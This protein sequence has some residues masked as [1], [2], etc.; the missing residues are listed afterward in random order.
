M[1]RRRGRRR[2]GGTSLVEAM[3]ALAV[4][5]FGM[6]AVVGIQATLRQNADTAK[7][8]SEAV[9]IAQDAIEAAR[10]FSTI[11]ITAGQSAFADIAAVANVGV[12][13]YTTN[14][15]YT[16]TQDITARTAPDHKELRVRVDWTDRNGQPQ[17]VELNSVIGANDP[18]VALALS[19]E[20]KGLPPRQ[21]V[22]RNPAIPPKSVSVGGGLSAFKPPSASGFVVWVFNDLTGL[23]VGVCN[24]VTTGQAALTG[25][26]VASCSNNTTAQPLS[27]F[28]RFATDLVQPTAAVAENPSSTALNL[29]IVLILTSL[30]HP[31]P[32]HECYAAAPPSS[33]LAAPSSS[34]RIT[35]V[36][37]YC[38]VFS[39]T[40]RLWTG[41][42]GVIPLGFSDQG[43]VPW[44][45]AVDAADAALNR[46]R[47]CRYTPAANDAEVIPNRQHPR[48]YTNVSELEPL[49]NQNFLVIRAGNGTVPFQC[50]TD[51][52]VDLA[53][54][55]LVNSNTL[56]HQPA[57]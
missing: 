18:R 10:A 54:G 38:A 28:V 2:I 49:A 15:S 24:T 17:R 48:I 34:E 16:L 11:D 55:N 23:I 7:Q 1:L 4:M 35:A 12:V 14:T 56:T 5:A 40:N 41:V 22:Q 25:A 32:S 46:Y 13:G 9:R 57:P 20:P 8:R 37:Y 51:V 50:P 44:D 36:P 43:N 21:N 6:L 53:T 19:A 33:S 52:P 39:N 42:S 3:V 29:R 31:V 26:D 45:I 27:G 30:G 47:V